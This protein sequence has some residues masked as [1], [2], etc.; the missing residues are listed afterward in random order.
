MLEVNK[1]DAFYDE[2]QVL[3]DVSL[4][5]ND[6]ELVTLLGPNGHGKS[7]LLKVISGLLRPSSGHVKFNG[8]E[9]DK[10]PSHKI[11]EMGIVYVSEERH[12]FP[13]LTIMENLKMGAYNPSARRDEDTN[14]NYVFQLFPG[15]EQ[16]K[17]QMASTLSGG[18]R[19]ML[20]IGRGLMSSAKF[21]ALDEPSLGLAPNLTDDVFNGISEINKS[22]ISILLVEQSIMRAS[23]LANRIY[24]MEDGKIVFE[25]G[26]EELLSNEHIKTAFLG[27]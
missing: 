13:D 4:K 8:V 3:K 22:G 2:I 27:M 25:G 24:F 16:R 21:L 26:K 17:K 6:G 9:I 19:R 15:L 1:V 12:L 18:E 7:T 20:A 5:V 23:E 11:V 10:L 14:A